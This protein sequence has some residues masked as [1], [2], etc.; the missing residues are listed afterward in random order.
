VEV[1]LTS[2]ARG[3]PEEDLPRAVARQRLLSWQT[4]LP[5]ADLADLIQMGRAVGLSMSE[6]QRL[7]GLARQTLY[8][9]LPADSER[10]P[11][12]PQIAVEVLMLLAAEGEYTSPAALA[13]R[14]GLSPVA[15]THAITELDAVDLCALRRDDYSS[16][17]AAPIPATYSVLREHFDDL[18]LR[19]PDATS[20]YFLV[21]EQF[22]DA[23]A[24]A[25]RRVLPEHEHALIPQSTAPSVMAGPELAVAVNAP[26]MRR[27]LDAARAS[28][29][30]VLS[31]SALEYFEPAVTNV[32]PPGS[33]PAIPS[34]T[35]DAFVEGMIDG[36]SP[37]GD[38][39]RELRAKYAGGASEVEIAGRCVTIAALAAR[40]AAGNQRNPRPVVDGDSAFAELQPASGV[41]VASQAE[42]VKKPAVASLRIA[43]DRLGP[44]PGGRLGSFRAPKGQ[45]NIVDGVDPT[46]SDLV[47]MARLAG[48]AAGAGA[49]LGHLDPAEI[50]KYVVL[51]QRRSNG[52]DDA[53][54]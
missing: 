51:G 45:P 47:E 14:A 50:L 34:E 37:N 53:T 52:D 49:H 33:R 27:A 42:A 24:R 5:V 3:I 6:M 9:H 4:D 2:I 39:L 17:E 16:L 15:V 36:G 35:L 43:T 29:S 26:T 22:E 8:R 11:A 19:R 32:I 18:Y 23:I 21:P 10:S 1:S 30:E 13:R 12:D 38:T 46:R 25:A 31:E 44:L 20:I 48:E 28:W 40:R 41:P 54:S 7:T